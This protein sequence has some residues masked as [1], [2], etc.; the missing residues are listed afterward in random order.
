MEISVANASGTCVRVC[1]RSCV[2][3]LGGVCERGTRYV[4]ERAIVSLCVSLRK[5]KCV[6]V[7]GCVREA[8]CERKG[9]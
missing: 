5:G 9:L 1:V 6:R 8:V 2:S 4:C 7:R 3:I